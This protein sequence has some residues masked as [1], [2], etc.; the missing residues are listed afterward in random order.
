MIYC[1]HTYYSQYI[2]NTCKKQYNVISTFPSNYG[3]TCEKNT[4]ISLD[5]STQLTHWMRDTTL[6]APSL[7]TYR[8]V[9]PFTRKWSYSP[10]TFSGEQPITTRSFSAWLQISRAVHKRHW[11]AQAYR[12]VRNQPTWLWEIGILLLPFR[13]MDSFWARCQ[14]SAPIV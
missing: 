3:E 8:Y 4:A 2:D 13:S 11:S 9:T 7:D 10:R 1:I 12:P 6:L 5:H 14:N